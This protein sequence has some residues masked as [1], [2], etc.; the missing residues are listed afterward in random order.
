MLFIAEAC[1]YA[2][3][4]AITGY[5]FGQ[6][7]AKF[8][9]DTGLL[10][11]L[12]L[13]YSSLAAVG[14]CGIVTLTVILSSLYP[15]FK[16]SKMAVPDVSRRWKQPKAEGDDLDFE[17]PFTVN[18]KDSIAINSF[19]AAYLRS[20]TETAIGKF[21]SDNIKMN[22]FDSKYG[23][24]FRIE[25]KIWIFP[26]ELGVSQNMIIE[27]VPIEDPGVFEVK[28]L[29]K[30]LSGETTTWNR[31]NRGFLDGIRKQFLTWRTVDETLKKRLNDDGVKEFGI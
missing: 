21:Y 7:L 3:V 26:L 23:R 17:L 24:A 13:N 18:I 20:H 28:F 16:A 9:S 14:A 6:T 31:M 4:G 30:R 8:V 15:A 22:V 12:S 19:L 1:V 2:T 27:T 25:T 10:K 29:I 5:L 11:G